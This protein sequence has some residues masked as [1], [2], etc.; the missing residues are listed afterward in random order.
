MLNLVR[1]GDELN[2]AARAL[3]PGGRRFTIT[4]PAPSRSGSAA[5]TSTC[6]SCWTW[7]GRLSDMRAVGEHAVSGALR[8]AIGRRYT[9]GDGPRACVDF[10]RRQITG[11]LVVSIAR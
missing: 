11:K 1:P 8:A 6:G 4:F 10:A 7:T 2:A 3:R 5:T 9:L